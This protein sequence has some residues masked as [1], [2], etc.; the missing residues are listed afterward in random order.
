MQGEIS[1]HVDRLKCLMFDT[2]KQRNLAGVQQAA[3]SVHEALQLHGVRSELCRGCG[4]Q[5]PS[6]AVLAVSQRLARRDCQASYGCCHIV[7]TRQHIQPGNC[8]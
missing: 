3:S 1:P 5:V 7:V 4:I 8:V 6:D 2:G